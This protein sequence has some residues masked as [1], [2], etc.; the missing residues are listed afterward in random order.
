MKTISKCIR[1][2]NCNF[3]GQINVCGNLYNIINNAYTQKK[4]IKK[5]IKEKK[6]KLR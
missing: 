4:R 2:Q 5:K 6:K 3:F 1:R